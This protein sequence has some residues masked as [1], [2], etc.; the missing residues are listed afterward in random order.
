MAADHLKS[1]KKIFVDKAK[2]LTLR[3]GSGFPI[4]GSTRVGFHLDG[5][6]KLDLGVNVKQ[7]QTH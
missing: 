5:V 1:I 3:I 6:H 4:S 2:S 7:G